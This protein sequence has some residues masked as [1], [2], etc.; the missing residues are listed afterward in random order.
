MRTRRYVL[1]FMES[2]CSKNRKKPPAGT[3]TGREVEM[4]AFCLHQELQLR[5]QGNHGLD[6]GNNQATGGYARFLQINA[7]QH[8][9]RGSGSADFVTDSACSRWYRLTCDG[10]CKFCCMAS[11]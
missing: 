8:E 6:P 4:M 10:W 5:P 3:P 1:A 11:W 2:A 9:A 7:N